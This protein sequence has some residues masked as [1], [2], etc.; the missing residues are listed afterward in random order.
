MD[1]R[2]SS[3]RIKLMGTLITVAGAVTLT[4]YRGPVVKDPS[5][6]LQLAPRLFVFLSHNENWVL[7]CALFAAASLSYSIWNIIQVLLNPVYKTHIII[8][9]RNVVGKC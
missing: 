9:S 8:T 4:L 6:H 7:G 5:A 2:S 1:L 3:S